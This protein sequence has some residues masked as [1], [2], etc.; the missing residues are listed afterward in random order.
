VAYTGGGPLG[1]N[2]N[3]T[4]LD[5][6]LGG[7]TV[8]DFMTFTGNA[9]LHFDLTA[10]G[11]GPSNT[12]CPASLDPNAAACSVAPGTP[13]K[14]AATTT[15]TDVTLSAVGIARD[16]SGIPSSWLGNY[17]TTFPGITPAQI[18]SA[19]L[20][21]LNVPGFCASGTCTST[22]SGTFSVIINPV[23]E[24]MSMALIGSGLIGL[25]LCKKRKARKA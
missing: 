22:Y 11:P 12:L 13:F 23:P 2:V 7:G 18:Q 9:N 14:L 6:T 25:A 21:G 10:L 3:G 15:G 19:I 17:S 5:L 1:Q 16:T 20:F 8:L 4:I 24:P